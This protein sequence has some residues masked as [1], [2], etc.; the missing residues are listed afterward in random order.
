VE[1]F[2]INADDDPGIGQ[3]QIRLLEGFDVLISTYIQSTSGSL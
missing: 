3:K 2:A 1:S